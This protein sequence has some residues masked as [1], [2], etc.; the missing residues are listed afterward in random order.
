M[1]THSNWCDKANTLFWEYVNYFSYLKKTFAYF[2]V[3]NISQVQ[4][5]RVDKLLIERIT[6]SVCE[7]KP[8]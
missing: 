2:R 3:S 5:H 6:D 4:N 7:I 1:A 8:L